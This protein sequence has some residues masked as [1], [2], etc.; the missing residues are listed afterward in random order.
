MLIT[1]FVFRK[2][3]NDIPNLTQ[4]VESRILDWYTDPMTGVTVVS[5]VLFDTVCVVIKMN[6]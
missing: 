1:D 4:F 2:S 6:G 3:D 5:I